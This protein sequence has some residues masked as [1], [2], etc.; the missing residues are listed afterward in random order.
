MPIASV[1]IVIYRITFWYAVWQKFSSSSFTQIAL[2]HDI[3]PY[4]AC[5]SNE[6][7]ILQGAAYITRIGW[8]ILIQLN[9]KY[10]HCIQ[11]LISKWH[12]WFAINDKGPTHWH[13][14]NI[15]E[16]YVSDS[17]SYLKESWFWFCCCE[18][19]HSWIQQDPLIMPYIGRRSPMMECGIARDQWVNDIR[20][21]P[22]DLV[23]TWFVSCM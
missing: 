6:Q 8:L 23:R 11:L 22:I 18:I 1:L 12:A 5:E 21:N 13:F 4:I 14:G 19:L 3:G 10:Y 7:A 16:I 20:A 17:Q 15:A 9:P 2:H